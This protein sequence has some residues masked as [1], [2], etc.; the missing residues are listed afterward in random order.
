MKVLD[1]QSYLAETNR[2]LTDDLFYKK[3][4]SDPTE[5]FL[6]PITETLDEMYENDDIGVNVYETLR[7]TNWRPGQFYLLPK[8]TGIH[9]NADILKI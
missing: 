1:K 9:R 2:Q 5:E 3:L 7:P 4:D 8:S 6:A